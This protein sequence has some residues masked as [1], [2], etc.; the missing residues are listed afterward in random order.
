MFPPTTAL[1]FLSTGDTDEGIGVKL[2]PTITL[3]GAAA[4]SALLQRAS[5]ASPDIL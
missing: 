2:I 1:T 5:G 3:F 4:Q